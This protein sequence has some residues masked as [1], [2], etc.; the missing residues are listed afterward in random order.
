LRA[1]VIDDETDFR[2]M[3][4]EWLSNRGFESHAPGMEAEV[5]AAVQSTPYDIVFLDLMMPGLNGMTLIPRVRTLN[6]KARVIV[7]S[8]VADVRVAIAAVRAGA[9]ACVEKPLDF[10]SLEQ[11][12]ATLQVREES[13]GQ[14][15]CTGRNRTHEKARG[16]A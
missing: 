6:P 2:E 9:D 14:D 7:V 1:L 15:A 5:L 3:L 16:S 4:A 8:A 10:R 12:L 13:Y 11:E